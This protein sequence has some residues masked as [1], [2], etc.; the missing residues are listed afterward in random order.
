MCGEGDDFFIDCIMIHMLCLS[1]PIE[2]GLFG[3]LDSGKAVL[4]LTYLL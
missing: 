3:V 1:I 4:L 2:F